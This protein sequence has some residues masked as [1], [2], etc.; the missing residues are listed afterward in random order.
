MSE[1]TEHPP[2]PIPVPWP[3]RPPYDL[4]PSHPLYNH[5]QHDREQQ[6]IE[7]QADV[8]SRWDAECD[9]FDRYYQQNS[10][11]R[12][13]RTEQ[14]RRH[15]VALRMPPQPHERQH[16]Q[17]HYELPADWRGGP[18]EGRHERWRDL[19][20]DYV[21]DGPDG[22]YAGVWKPTIHPVTDIYGIPPGDPLY[23][24][25][26]RYTPRKSEHGHAQGEQ[27]AMSPPRP[28]VTDRLNMA[29]LRSGDAPGA[30][31]S[32]P[33]PPSPLPVPYRPTDMHGDLGRKPPGASRSIQQD[34]YQEPR[35]P[36]QTNNARTSP[37]HGH[38]SRGGNGYITPTLGGEH[39]D[40]WDWTED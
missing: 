12:R 15:T 36:T 2:S 40:L 24:P 5:A 32:M 38:S 28:H 8:Q 26:L 14:A 11:I 9:E 13:A 18:R 10:R 35:Y 27:A 39:L 20:R 17:D 7:Q 6:A 34:R 33:R 23:R 31:Y 21:R 29:S 25:H 4:E 3:F 1:P 19:G 30:S 37:G 22:E 16:D